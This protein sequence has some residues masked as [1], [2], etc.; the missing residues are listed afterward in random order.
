M[1]KYPVFTLVIF[2]LLMYSCKKNDTDKAI[3]TAYYQLDNVHDYSV[4]DGSV[5][6]FN[7][8]FT[9]TDAAHPRDTFTVT[10]TGMPPG[11]AVLPASIKVWSS[12]SIRFRFTAAL[13]GVGNYPI[14][15]K[16][17]APNRIEKNYNFNI[18]VQP[19][20]AAAIT[21]SWD[22]YDSGA[23]TFTPANYTAYVLLN[24]SNQ[25]DIQQATRTLHCK[26]NC[27]T[28]TLTS[29]YSFTLPGTYGTGT[30]A[31]NRIVVRHITT[32]GSSSNV[33]CYSILTR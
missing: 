24:A 23:V 14:T 8:A 20:C 21:G 10:P 33:T 9:L 30:F 13:S 11:L 29:H 5:T 19:E 28:G 12:D 1:K 18:V 16:C 7:A 3:S 22:C 6:P 15:L 32:N 25:I 4:I 26:L 31:S 2:L 17:T 27:N